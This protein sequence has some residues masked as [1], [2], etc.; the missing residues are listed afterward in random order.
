MHEL[1]ARR[2]EIPDTGR[3]P[4]AFVWTRLPCGCFVEWHGKWTI[5]AR[6]HTCAHRYGDVVHPVTV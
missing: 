6:Q 5:A 4:A 3:P 1:S 2:E